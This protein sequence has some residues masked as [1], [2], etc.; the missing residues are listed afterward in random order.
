[1]WIRSIGDLVLLY[2]AMADE[3]RAQYRLGYEPPDTNADGQWHGVAVEHGDRVM[4]SAAP[5]IWVDRAEQLNH[6]GLP[7]PPQIQREL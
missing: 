2:K 4:L 1:M 6:V 3:L 7:R 5:G